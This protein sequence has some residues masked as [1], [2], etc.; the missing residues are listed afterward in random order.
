MNW[1]V[2]AGAFAVA[3]AFVKV[4]RGR[5]AKADGQAN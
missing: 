5:V 1:I 4:R 2:L 3:F